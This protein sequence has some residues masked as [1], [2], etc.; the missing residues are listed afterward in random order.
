MKQSF[1]EYLRD[2]AWEPE[3][4]LDDD[5]PDAFDTWLSELDVSELIKYGEEYGKHIAYEIV[6]DIQNNLA[7]QAIEL[8]DELTNYKK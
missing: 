1:E 6:S 4:V 3:G 5:M 7:K 8:H 2:N